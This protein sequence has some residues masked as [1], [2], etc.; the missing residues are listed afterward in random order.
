MRT[1]QRTQITMRNRMNADLREAEERAEAQRMAQLDW[2]AWV[3]EQESLEVCIRNGYDDAFYV[4]GV[5]Q[6]GTGHE[7]TRKRPAATAYAEALRLA[8]NSQLGLFDMRSKRAIR[9]QVAR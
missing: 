2:P 7:E 1:K 4:I 6:K 9:R 3:R 5:T 8:Q